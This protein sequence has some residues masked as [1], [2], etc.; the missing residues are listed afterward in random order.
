MIYYRYHT[1]FDNIFFSM[2]T[3]MIRED[4]NQAGFVLISNWPLGNRI[5]I[6]D[7]RICVRKRYYLI[8]CQSSVAL[9]IS[10]NKIWSQVQIFGFTVGSRS[11]LKLGQFL[12][13]RHHTPAA[14]LFK[15][16]RYGGYLKKLCTVNLCLDFT[17]FVQK[18]GKIQPVPDLQN[19][20][21]ML[22]TGIQADLDPKQ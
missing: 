14:R 10:V 5:R 4:S 1:N 12:C 19:C 15:G 21:D 8:Y 3:K 16:S 7:R 9:P 2:A 18:N 17:V 6:M 11:D 13:Q 22:K 20:M